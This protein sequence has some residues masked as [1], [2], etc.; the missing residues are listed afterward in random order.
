MDELHVDLPPGRR[1]VTRASRPR[2]LLPS[3]PPLP[4]TRPTAR[5]ATAHRPPAPCRHPAATPRPADDVIDEVIR[6][7]VITPES[8]TSSMTSSCLAGPAPG[9]GAGGEGRA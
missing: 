2:R 1:F 3:V 8:M 4:D 6:T 7:G 9:E 5:D